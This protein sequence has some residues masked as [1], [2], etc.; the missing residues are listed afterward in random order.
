MLQLAT[1]EELVRPLRLAVA[2]R[3]EEPLML[4]SNIVVVL[5]LLVAWSSF[6]GNTAAAN[7]PQDRTPPK[8][9]AN[10]IYRAG[11]TPD[12]IIL[13]WNG[14]PAT[15]VAVTWRTSVA[16]LKGK[17]EFLPAPHG[18]IKSSSATTA[19]AS[20]QALLTD[21]GA[22]IYHTASLKKLKPGTKYVYRVGDGVNWSEWFHYTTPPKKPKPFSFIYF[23]DAQT[24]LKSQWSRVIREAYSDAPKASFMIHAGDLVDSSEADT[25]WGQWHAAGGWLNGMIPSIATPGN[26]EQKTR[27]GISRVSHHWRPQFAF[28]TNGPAGLEETCYTMVYQNLRIIS[29]NSNRLIKEQAIWLDKILSRNKAKWV[30]CTFHHPMFSTD[31]ARDNVSQRKAWKPVFDKHRVDLV[32]QGHDHTYARTGLKTPPP[33]WTKLANLA[34]G[35]NATDPNSGTVY[36]VSVS[37]PKMYNMRAYDFFKRQREKTQLYQVVHIDGDKLS[38]EARTAAGELHDAFSLE[39][40]DGQINKLV[41]QR[42]EDK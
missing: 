2:R 13:T 6:A 31:V 28:P 36:V 41:E 23:G 19:K 3:E 10:T 8:A 9:D 1:C 21:T 22:A 4:R 40:Q 11:V 16:T 35:A 39:K 38:Y 5:M 15:S 12:R 25:Q 27:D 34:T 33:E 32:L 37:G 18:P 7:G 26:H 42:P 30:V 29:L 20:S 17:A 24:E 14:D